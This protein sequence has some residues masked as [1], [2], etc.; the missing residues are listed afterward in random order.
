MNSPYPNQQ[1]AATFPPRLLS[2]RQARAFVAGALRQA[3]VND[4]ELADRLEMVTSELGTNA[5]LHAGTEIDARLVVDARDVRLEV[6]DRAGRRPRPAP[7]SVTST[8]GRGL[9]LVDAM[10]D[11]WGGSATPGGAGKTV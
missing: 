6:A 7:P 4:G 9:V 10:V 8:G 3:G 2:A 5:V 1:M 11:D